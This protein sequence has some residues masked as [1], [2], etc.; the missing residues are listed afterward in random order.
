MVIIDLCTASGRIHNGVLEEA[1]RTLQ[2]CSTG[3]LVRK[4]PS[5]TTSQPH[6][7][8]R[9]DLVVNMRGDLFYLPELKMGSL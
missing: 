1:K 6:V 9:G 2:G 4:F 3:P 7:G 8:E 5:P